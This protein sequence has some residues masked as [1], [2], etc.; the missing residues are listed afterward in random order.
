MRR[1]GF[2]GAG[3]ALVMSFSLRA[4]QPAAGTTTPRAEPQNLG[5]VPVQNAKLPGSLEQQPL[6]DAWIR[7][8]ADNSVTVVTG[9]VELGQGIKTALLQVAAEEL[10]VDPARIRL[11]TADTGDTPN[12]GYTAGSSS[13]S[14]SGTAL[15]NAASQVRAIL[16]GRAAERLGVAVGELTIQDGTVV[17]PGGKRVTYG[18]LVQ[19]DVLHVNAEP[20]SPLRDPRSRSVMGKPM[21]RVD[22]PAKV[23]GQPIY[24]QDFRPPGMVHAR[25]MRP[26]SYTARLVSMDEAAVQRL[27]GVLKIVR[28]GSHV[29]VVAEREYQAVKAVRALARSARWEQRAELAGPADVFAQLER[30]PA[31]RRL[32][33]DRPEGAPGGRTIEATYRRP[34]QMHASIGPSC[35]V[36]L[37]RDGGVTVWTHSQGV[38]PLRGA[39]AEM[40]SLPPEQVRCIHMEGSGC[41][42]HNAA[43]DVAADAALVA[44]GFPGRPVRVQWMREDEHGWEPYGSAMVGTVRARLGDAGEVLDWRYEV[45]SGSHLTRPGKAGNLA[46]AWHLDPP[47]ALPTPK[48]L[49]Q[50]AGGGDR[51][52]IPYYT[53]PVSQVVHHF[54]PAMPMRVSA[55]RGLG[56]YLNVFALESFMDEL[57]AAAKVDPVEFRLRNLSDPRAQDVIRKAAER[58]GWSSFQRAP[59]R[60][61]GFA[62]ARYKNYAGYCAIA[63]E[64]AVQRDTGRVHVRRAIAAAD[65]GEAVNPDGIRNQI[66]G[67]IVQSLS[68]TLY[69][70]VVTDTTRVTSLDWGGYPILRFPAVPDHVE[71]HLISRLGTPFL[72]TGEVSQGPTGAAVANAIADAVGVRLRDLPLTRERVRAAVG[73]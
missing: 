24:V 36:G 56:A 68:W 62:F 39:L 7:I 5:E 4:A 17:G 6:L 70:G 46:P 52:A 35:A 63:V 32:V 58:F 33:V 30:L 9:K 47:F 37:A 48:P 64:V 61:R 51:N 41:Y 53:F 26:P 29:A 42:G 60:G 65:S 15:M 13:M 34:Y 16:L 28:N 25:V 22:I 14:D 66:E 40:L 57:A 38:Y 44:V 23:T 31:E 10:M 43:D 55:L 71:V 49:P 1:R 45:R 3:G 8:A 59:G 69:E 21:R 67:G 27:P 12:E 18:A 73:V 2:L 54:I 11:I 72:G 20:R 19:G 50:P